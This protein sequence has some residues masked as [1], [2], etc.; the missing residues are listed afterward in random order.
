ME[1]GEN[2]RTKTS[3]QELALAQ[4]WLILIYGD[5]ISLSIVGNGDEKKPNIHLNKGRV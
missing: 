1:E 4:Q 3:K 2:S 5:A